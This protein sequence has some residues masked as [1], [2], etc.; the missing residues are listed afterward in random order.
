M[1]EL[2]A[3]RKA[4]ATAIRAIGARP[5]MFEQ[6]AG[7]DADPEQAYLS[8]VETSDIYVGILGTVERETP[9]TFAIWPLLTF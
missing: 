6:F 7:R 9:R 8:E 1:S 3:E 5:V 4:A 2:P